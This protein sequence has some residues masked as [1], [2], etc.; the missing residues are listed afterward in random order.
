[1]SQ[2]KIT[3]HSDLCAGSGQS[4]GNRVDTDICTDSY[5]IPYIPA[6]RIKG[7]LLEAAEELHELGYP[8]ATKEAI[9]EIFGGKYGEEGRLCLG[10]AKLP[11]I[12]DIHGYIEKTKRE[13]SDLEKK[14]V[15]P[16]SISRM[17]SYQRGQTGLKD[18]VKVDGTLRF[19]NV[20]KHYDPLDNKL[21]REMEFFAEVE[22][23]DSD[24][25]EE[26]ISACCKAVRHMGMNRNR[27][28][29]NVSLEFIHKNS[30][31]ENTFSLKELDPDRNYI[32]EYRITNDSALTLPDCEGMRT[33]IPSKSIIGILA[34]RYLREHEKDSVFNRLFLDGS[35]V[36]SDITPVINSKISY[37]VPMFVTRLKNYNGMIINRFADNKDLD[38]KAL[39]PKTID[40]GYMSDD[41]NNLSIADLPLRSVYH[42]SIKTR[43]LTGAGLYMQDSID[44][45]YIFGGTVRA[46][47]RYI[48]IIADLLKQ[49]NL[50]FGRS[51]SAQYAT[52]HLTDISVKD[53]GDLDLTK[54]QIGEPVFVCLKSDM[55]PD[56]KEGCPV[57]SCDE[58]RKV[59]AEQLELDNVIPQKYMDL[60]SFRTTGGYQGM[61]HLQKPHIQVIS[62][63]SVFC[64]VAKKDA[65]PREVQLG[66][67][68]QEGYG[69][70]SVYS[71]REF[72]ELKD[73]KK[74][75][76][77]R[78]SDDKADAGTYQNAFR[79]AAVAN[80][81]M[82]LIADHAESVSKST[83]RLKGERAEGNKRRKGIPTGKMRL[84]TF[85]A[86]TYAELREKVDQIKESDVDSASIGRRWECHELLD[87]LYGT[88]RQKIS[89]AAMVGIEKADDAENLG[90]DKDVQSMLEASWKKPLD[91]ALHSL[92]YSGGRK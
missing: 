15:H 66:R 68:R 87:K 57:M 7:C 10:D 74:G 67:N 23:E 64:F 44:S 60:I 26:L 72:G 91:I 13:G 56:G 14:A 5:G 54:T 34:G 16:N 8:C 37:P 86:A 29:G 58:I 81:C 61:W 85:E 25:F 6:R 21:G 20:L 59:I 41:G 53:S 31:S 39:K 11:G 78:V 12:G 9:E 88:D 51:R 22:G 70:C 77:D 42:N 50:S 3:L 69:I 73:I 4:L 24:S 43:E 2:I 65:Y 35:T 83:M 79:Q 27:G 48:K 52:C 92:H 62:A 82:E 17:Y 89:C 63:G 19:I 28:L 49:G 84:I 36:W 1:M 32:L 40:T 18:G 47:G 38:W 33:S 76:V 30:A 45:G 71:Y 80:A 75:H 90:I 55:L 46:Q